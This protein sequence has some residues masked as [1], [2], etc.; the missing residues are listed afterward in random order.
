MIETVTLDQE[1]WAQ[2]ASVFDDRIESNPE[3]LF[4]G[5]SADRCDA[6]ER[7]GLCP[8]S[9]IAGKSELEALCRIFEDLNWWGSHVSGYAVVRAY[10]LDHDFRAG[11][12]TPAF[13]T[14]FAFQAIHYATFA[15]AGGEKCRAVRVAMKDLQEFIENEQ[16]RMEALSSRENRIDPKRSADVPRID[17]LKSRLRS[18]DSLVGRC[19]RVRDE[20]VEG[21]VYALRIPEPDRVSFGYSGTMGYRSDTCIPAERIIAKCIIPSGF[22]SR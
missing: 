13:L 22:R 7:M 8:G 10:S 6:I 21:A 20:F 16:F 5:T 19:C 9:S 15:Y 4:H 14:K 12:V 3:V 11:E 2:S 18:F 17:E 1:R